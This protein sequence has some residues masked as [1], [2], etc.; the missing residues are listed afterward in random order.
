MSTIQVSRLLQIDPGLAAQVASRLNQEL[1]STAGQQLGLERSIDV[2]LLRAPPQPPLDLAQFRVRLTQVLERYEASLQAQKAEHVLAAL[3]QRSTRQPMRRPKKEPT[4]ASM[5]P[6]VADRLLDPAAFLSACQGGR[7]VRV[8]AY[9][10]AGGDVNKTLLQERGGESTLGVHAAVRG[11]HL[12]VVAKLV[13]GGATLALRS[14][15]DRASALHVAVSASAETIDPRIVQLLLQAG[16]DAHARDSRKHRTPLL[17]LAAECEASAKVSAAVTRG[18]NAGGAEPSPSVRE[19]GSD[20]YLVKKRARMAEL[21]LAEGGAE[22]GASDSAGR[23]ALCYARA[24]G[25][26]GTLLL[27]VLCARYA[28]QATETS[29]SSSTSSPAATGAADNALM[30]GRSVHKGEGQNACYRGPACT[31]CGEL[32][33]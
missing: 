33:R 9:M 25:P 32:F 11:G 6:A 20:A 27:H 16:A 4:A 22:V 7:L 5:R 18:R 1:I 31:F 8:R 23:T 21:L 12:E 24:A 17:A 29:P 14:G 26:Q 28:M 10:Q 13:S 3:E 15:K 19:E 2:D 30:A